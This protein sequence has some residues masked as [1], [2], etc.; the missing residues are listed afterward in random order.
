[1][2]LPSA[3]QSSITTS[4]TTVPPNPR[5]TFATGSGTAATS[6]LLTSAPV[7]AVQQHVPV[8]LFDRGMHM[9]LGNEEG[10]AKDAVA[11]LL[12]IIMNIV[13][14]PMEEKYRKVK[15]SSATFNAKIGSISGGLNCL[16]AIGF[17]LI[18][19]DWVLVPSADAWPILLACQAKLDRFMIKY[20]EV[21]ASASSSTAHPTEAPSNTTA[22][23]GGAKSSV[24]EEEAS[25]ALE[26]LMLAMAMVQPS[27]SSQGGGLAASTGDVEDTTDHGHKH[28]LE[29]DK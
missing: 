16:Q 9:L 12:K 17:Q 1:M 19:E 18:G 3:G 28:S 14:H 4:S 24:S 2:K 25:K 27:T 8:P 29:E 15:S 10:V 6:P 22:T 5:A 26:Q 13:N 11:M 20:L 21:C 23:S 7:V